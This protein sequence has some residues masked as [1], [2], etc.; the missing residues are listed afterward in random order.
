MRVSTSALLIFG[1]M[2]AASGGCAQTV[3][4]VTPPESPPVNQSVEETTPANEIPTTTVD[5][6]AVQEAKPAESATPAEGESSAEKKSAEET[7]KR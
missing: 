5:S 6:P 4:P 3:T 1:L 2:V 7:P